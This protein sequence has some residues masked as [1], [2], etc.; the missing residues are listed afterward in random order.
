MDKPL[1]QHTI[2]PVYDAQSR[3]LL[4]GSFPSVRSRA[5]G[6][7]YAHPQNRFWRVLAAL[8]SCPVP[9]TVAEKTSLLHAQHL[10]LWDVCACCTVIGS[11][12]ASIRNVVAN[13]VAALLG[14]TRIRAVFANGTTAAALY[15]RFL[16]TDCA[17]P[18]I[19]LPSTSPANASYSLE[20]LVES[21]SCV[22]EEILKQENNLL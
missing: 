4:L 19:R 11:G 15:H 6:F 18:A 21:W 8:F 5:E 16:E 3:V 9:Q 10:A 2:A 22:R 20:R 1:Y 14:G 17:M 7:Y 13:D 12:D